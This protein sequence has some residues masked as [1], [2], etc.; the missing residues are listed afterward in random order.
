ML[1]PEFPSLKSQPDYSGRTGNDQMASHWFHGR[2]ASPYAGT[3][4]S[5]GHTGR[6]IRR[7]SISRGRC[8]SRDGSFTQGGQVR[9]DHLLSQ[10]WLRPLTFST[11]QL[12]S[13]PGWSWKE[14]LSVVASPER[15]A[16]RFRGFL[17]WCSAS[18]VFC[19]L[20]TA[21]TEDPLLYCLFNFRL[22]REW[23]TEGQKW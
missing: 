21:R 23:R 19:R 14:D 3:S 1:Q 2:A 5:L 17:F 12:A 9:V 8:S 4:R 22:S 11:R 10:L 18:M 15:P 20:L 7:Q 6:V 16:T 13:S